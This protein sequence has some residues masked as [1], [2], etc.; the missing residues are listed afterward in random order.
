MLKEL[1]K[2]R[3]GL[4]I[5]AQ[6]NSKSKLFSSSSEDSSQNCQS[7]ENT[8]VFD[9]GLP[10]VL[11][12]LNEEVIKQAVKTGLALNCK[13]NEV[14]IF[15]RKHYFYQDLPFGYQ[16]TQFYY[17]ICSKGFLNLKQGKK[18]NIERIHLECDAGKSLHLKNETLI[19]YNRSGIALMEIVTCP[20]IQSLDEFKEFINELILHLR[21]SDTC[22]CNL[23]NGNLRIDANISIDKDNG[24]WGTRVEIKNLNSINFAIDALEYEYNRQLA[25]LEKGE[26]INQETRGYNS[27]T[28]VTFN[29]RDKEDAF[30]YRYV[31]DYNIPEV[32]ISADYIDKI[33]KV[34]NKMPNDYRE[35]L[36]KLN[37]SEDTISTLVFN[38]DLLNYFYLCDHSNA[39]LLCNFLITDLMK[40]INSSEENILNCKLTPLYLNKI[41]Q[42]QITN[43][44]STKVAKYLIEKVFN[45]GEDP[46]ILI[47]KENLGKII[48]EIIL[49][50]YID[51]SLLE[52]PNEVLRYKN[53]EEKLLM[54]FLGTVIKKTNSRADPDILKKLLLQLL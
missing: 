17:P 24:E 18:I 41:V 34:L 38:P 46:E 47:E 51:E 4:E 2:I 48:D 14:S 22:N 49:K 23:E 36:K 10:G 32:K 26:H 52:F 30:D 40:M 21:Y 25:K 29:M 7:N 3:I 27:E 54:F 11:P 19:D 20:D 44:I 33:K 8:T 43:I 12:R 42:L 45:T 31:P 13:I 53:G 37:L 15:D 28:K 1:K 9:L 16:I 5:H 39:Q 35:E 6:V 50:K